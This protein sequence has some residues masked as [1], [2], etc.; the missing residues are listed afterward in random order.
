MRTTFEE[1]GSFGEQRPLPGEVIS[2][3][4]TN[5]RNLVHSA[6]ALHVHPSAEDLRRFS[7]CTEIAANSLSPFFSEEF[8]RRAETR[9]PLELSVE[10][11][12]NA[13][14]EIAEKTRVINPGWTAVAEYTDEDREIILAKLT[15]IDDDV[16][17]KEAM[18]LCNAYA[19]MIGNMKEGV[20]KSP[21]VSGFLK[22]QGRKAELKK[23]S[24]NLGV[25]AVG[26]ILGVWLTQRRKK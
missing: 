1:E 24:I 15:S 25:A 18:D 5:H 26:T 22:K 7:I 2:I 11:V 17:K 21:H 16:A 20:I 10:A 12:T 23:H 19:M 8:F 9:I 4:Q 6:L 3:F 14:Q 13:T